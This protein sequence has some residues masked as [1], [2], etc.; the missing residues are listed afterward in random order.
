MVSDLVLIH[1]LLFVVSELNGVCLFPQVKQPQ[2]KRFE[3]VIDLDFPCDTNEFS[4]SSMLRVIKY[5]LA[6]NIL[7]FSCIFSIDQRFVVSE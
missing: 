1:D 2:F 6:Q 7:V 5:I 3:K 4:F